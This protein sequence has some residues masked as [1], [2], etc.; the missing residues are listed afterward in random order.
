MRWRALRSVYRTWYVSCVQPVK[1]VPNVGAQIRKARNAAGLS[2]V[3]LA[4]KLKIAERT[5]QSW[6]A[7]ERTP[8]LAG[9]TSLARSLG[10]PVGFFYGHDDLPPVEDIAA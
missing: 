6:E 7:N 9:L 3:A 8:R 4:T 2:Q 10:Q 5:V 1:S